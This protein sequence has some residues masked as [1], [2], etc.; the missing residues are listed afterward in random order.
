MKREEKLSAR[1]ELRLVK[2][3]RNLNERRMREVQTQVLHYTHLAFRA[4]GNL[5]PATVYMLLR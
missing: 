5:S 2:T 4:Q 1:R 3:I